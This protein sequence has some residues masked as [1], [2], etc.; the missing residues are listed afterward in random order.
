M[1]CIIFV[2]DIAAKS[3][4]ESIPGYLEYYKSKEQFNQ[5]ALKI[6]VGNRNNADRIRMVTEEEGI[7]FAKEKDMLFFETSTEDGTNVKEVFMQSV[8]IILD[9]INIGEI[10]LNNPSCG[11]KENKRVGKDKKCYKICNCHIF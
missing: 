7:K 9:R 4:F 11:I 5:S 10:N 2:Y 3:S 8:R 6:L 1:A